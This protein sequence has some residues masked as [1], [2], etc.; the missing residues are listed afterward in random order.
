MSKKISIFLWTTLALFSISSDATIVEKRNPT[1][2]CDSFY[3]YVCRLEATP[4]GTKSY[5]E[6]LRDEHSATVKKLL[7]NLTLF[8]RCMDRMDEPSSFERLIESSDSAYYGSDNKEAYRVKFMNDKKRSGS[9]VSFYSVLWTVESIERNGFGVDFPVKVQLTKKLDSLETCL[10]VSPNLKWLNSAYDAVSSDSFKKLP[11]RSV[12][13]PVFDFV[14]KLKETF[15]SIASEIDNASFGSKKDNDDNND[16]DEISRYIEGYTT[17][18]G[19]D[20]RFAK[21]RRL[22][23]ASAVVVTAN[24]SNRNLFWKDVFMN[25]Y[26]VKDGSFCL[27][28][29]GYEKYYAIVEKYVT[30]PIDDVDFL[31]ALDAF[32]QDVK[33]GKF[34]TTAKTKEGRT[35][36]EEKIRRCEKIVRKAVPRIVNDEFLI[37]SGAAAAFEKDF[38][39]ERMLNGLKKAIN[40]TIWESEHLPEEFKTFASKKMSTLKAFVMNKLSPSDALDDEAKESVCLNAED[41]TE[42]MVCLANRKATIE[43]DIVKRALKSEIKEYGK[44]TFGEH[45]EYLYENTDLSIVNAWYD[46]TK[47]EI[48]IPAGIVFWPMYSG[49]AFNANDMYDYSRMGMILAHELGHALDSNGLCWDERGNYD[50]TKRYCADDKL[51][52]P[53]K[54]NMECLMTDY[55][56]PCGTEDGYGERTLGEDMADQLGLIASWRIFSETYGAFLRLEDEREFFR[57]YAQLWCEGKHPKIEQMRSVKTT[58]LEDAND[59]RN[60]YDDGIGKKANLPFALERSKV[61]KHYKISSKQK[62]NTNLSS[63]EPSRTDE[64]RWMCD[65]VMN[66]VHALPKHRVNKALR[67]LTTFSTLFDCSSN[68]EMY[69]ET[70]C[71][72]Y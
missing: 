21:D 64:E 27:H 8:D 50:A 53:I 42:T 37:S 18:E 15:E 25:L 44:M 19:Y 6:L 23:V 56:H 14:R 33:F 3:D 65:K 10:D 69:K 4:A 35:T 26:D 72:I 1:G 57:K 7:T 66:D 22:P 38:S 5:F 51:P 49:N 60:E 36:T 12:K 71:V 39:V 61:S 52:V 16:D 34:S 32:S 70:P 43:K 17:I 13:K 46:P 40:E 48:T 31:E 9:S 11:N 28:A 68:S 67:Q 41:W 59:K 62:E 54:R 20:R 45:Y 63:H 30:F 29:N 47:N 58:T 2:E 24:S 55:G